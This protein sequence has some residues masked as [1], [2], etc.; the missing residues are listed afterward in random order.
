MS[1]PE[2]FIVRW[3]RRKREA[4]EEVEAVPTS[5]AGDAMP[6]GTHVPEE[7]RK[8]SDATEMRGLSEH[9]FDP[10]SLP[11]LETITRESDIRA[12]LA[13]GVPAE[14]TR[15]ALRRAWAADPKIRDFVGLADYDWDFNT[16]GAMTGF[17]ALEM[18]D[19]LRR[20]VARMVGRSGVGEP[21]DRPAPTPAQ[22]DAGRPP[23]ETSV[24]SA[25]TTCDVPTQRDPSNDGTLQS[26]PAA[27]NEE[28]Y[29]SERTSQC[30]TEDI[31]TQYDPPAPN[32]DQSMAKRLHGGALP[33]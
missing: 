11:P 7:Q 28:R 2:N 31:A 3:S 15:V 24:E 17:G 8:E 25:A 32:N 23:V 14:L 27:A 4:T 6:D 29:N 21:A 5:A 22:V 10:A 19:E 9:P 12:F 1:E 30:N 33:K 16:P 18:T 13:P 20:E 26:E